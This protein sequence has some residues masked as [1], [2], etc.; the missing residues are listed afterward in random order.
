MNQQD[1]SKCSKI[2]QMTA[3]N[4]KR[5]SNVTETLLAGILG[6]FNFTL[7]LCPMYRSYLIPWYTHVKM[8]SSLGFTL[9]VPSPPPPGH[10][11]ALF[12]H[13]DF[14]FLWASQFLT[15]SPDQAAE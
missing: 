6:F 5:L 2:S 8:L 9:L 11:K 12:S 15:F 10:L 1:V 4:L 13:S 3:N 14:V 7:R